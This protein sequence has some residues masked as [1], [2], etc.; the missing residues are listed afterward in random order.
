MNKWSSMQ[1]RVESYLQVRRSVGYI[2]R[3]EGEQLLRF[4]SFADQRGHQGCITIDLAVV[5][6]NS[7]QKSQQIGRARRLE[8]VRSLAKY[9]VIFESGTEVPPPHLL[10]S[11][12]RRATPHIYN[13]RVI[14]LLL[15]TA[16]GLQPKLGLRPVTMHC[17]LGLLASTGLRI[18][19]AL[20]LK[21]NDVDLDQ[22]VLQIRKSKFRKSRYVPLHQKVCEELSGYA[23]FRDQQLPVVQ[24]PAFF[25]LDNGRS[26]QYRQALYA[27]QCIRAQL[28]W[29]ICSSGRTPRLYDLRHT[30]VCRRLLLW[31]A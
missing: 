4:A 29:D 24:N 23:A 14:I 3:I 20:R 5:W 17:L 11:A 9:C 28:G 16:N 30:F 15:D 6:A 8:V 18:S 25:L 21:R 10:G 22:G 12:H 1:E 19:E 31:Y 26:L 13:D 27:F 2:L 7:S